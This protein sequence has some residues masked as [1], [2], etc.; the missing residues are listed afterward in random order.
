[1]RQ[2]K[3]EYKI[4]IAYLITGC[5]WILFSDEILDYFIEDPDMLT[6]MQIFKGWFYVLI[7]GLLFI[8]VKQPDKGLC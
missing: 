8:D 3:F 6:M 7:T 2:F 5:F 1:M 4:T